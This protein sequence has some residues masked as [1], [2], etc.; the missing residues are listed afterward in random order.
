MRLKSILEVILTQLKLGT[1]K[2][3]IV[4]MALDIIFTIGFIMI[5]SVFLWSI[6]FAE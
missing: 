4:I 6:F 1:T 3:E 2:M 5:A